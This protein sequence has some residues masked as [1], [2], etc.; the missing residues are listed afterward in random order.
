MCTSRGQGL[1]FIGIKC[2]SSGGPQKHRHL[3][4]VKTYILHKQH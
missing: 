3:K 4:Y 1:L 2:T